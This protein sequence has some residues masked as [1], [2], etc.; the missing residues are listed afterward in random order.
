MSISQTAIDIVSSDPILR[1]C[2]ARGIVN[3][4]KLAKLI[5]PMVSQI[6]G[7]EVSV[8]VIKVALIRYANRF[9]EEANT[10]RDVL[11][12]IA[13]SSVEV[14]TDITI[15]IARSYI[16]SYLSQ[17]ISRLL[18]RSRFL[19]IMQSV[20]ATTIVADKD[21]AEEILKSVRSEDL[22]DV[23]KGYGAIVIVSP[24][25]IMTTPGVLAYIANV[26]AQNNINIVHVESCYTDTIIVVSRE[27]VE[28]T[29]R[30]IMNHIEGAKKILSLLKPS[31]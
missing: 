20:T 31:S 18:P 24:Q 30:I 7:K 2:I 15:I 5:Q 25:E 27:D 3:Y 9:V 26:L 14:R 22:I 19:A 4:R 16:T 6:V 21:T 23:Q 10:R 29:F 8:D 28:K 1:Q 13:N 12:I 17:A 11:E